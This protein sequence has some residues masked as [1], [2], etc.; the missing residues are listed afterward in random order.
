MVHKDSPGVNNRSEPAFYGL[1]MW[2]FS[3]V[4]IITPQ[5]HCIGVE[6]TAVNGITQSQVIVFHFHKSLHAQ[7]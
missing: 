4:G 5:L 6:L 1:R 2:D 7:K 3:Q